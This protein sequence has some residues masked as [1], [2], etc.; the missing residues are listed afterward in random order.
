MQTARKEVS[1]LVSL[2]QRQLSE[3]E[4]ELRRTRKKLEK[5]LNAPAY[6]GPR[7]IVDN[8]RL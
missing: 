3:Q 7:L 1:G 8:S 4:A 5:L 2:L 6:A